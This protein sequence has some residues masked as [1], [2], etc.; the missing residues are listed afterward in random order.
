MEIELSKIQMELLADKVARKL[1]RLQR[2]ERK[3]KQQDD[4]PEMVDTRGAAAI[5]NISVGRMR[6]IKDRFP[7]TKAGEHGQGK[8][9]F[10]K[11]ALLTN[12]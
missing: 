12:Y 9:L 8:L 2:E 3:Q 10:V 5:L 6:Q 7:H 1:H 11:S 4:T